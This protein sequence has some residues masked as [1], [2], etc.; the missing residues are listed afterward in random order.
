M[1]CP[2]CQNAHHKDCVDRPRLAAVSKGKIKGLTA[3]AS[4]WC[5]C[6]HQPRDVPVPPDPPQPAGD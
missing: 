3:G 6:A 2:P 1:I 4:S 5:D